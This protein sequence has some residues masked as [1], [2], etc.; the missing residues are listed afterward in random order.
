MTVLLANVIIV[1]CCCCR[2]RR[3]YCHHCG[4]CHR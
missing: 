1:N 4:C 3:C 2:R